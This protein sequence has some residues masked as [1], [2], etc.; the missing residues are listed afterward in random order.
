MADL[1]VHLAARAQLAASVPPSLRERVMAREW[2]HTI[3]LAQDLLTPGFFDHRTAAARILPRTLNGRRCLD[4]ATMDGFWAIEMT[5]RAA[6]EVVALDVPEPS[7]WDWPPGCDE[8]VIAAISARKGAGDGFSIAMEALH[9]DIERVEQSVYDLD[10]ADVGQFDFVYVGSLLLHL[11][12]PVRALERVRSVCCGELLL[13]EN[14]DPITTLLHPRRPVATFDGIG[15]PWW[16][17]LNL[18]ALERVVTSAGFELIGSPQRLRFPRGKG[19]VMPPLRLT[20]LRVPA[21]RTELREGLL[22]DPHLA[23]Q[24]RPRPGA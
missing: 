16:W 2:Y 12:D 13:V 18:A 20:S 11:R 1:D 7:D 10:P 15:R 19:W 23:L 14:F 24:A 9:Y 17:R 4:V 22:G 6:D 5:V 21:L 3:E 8:A